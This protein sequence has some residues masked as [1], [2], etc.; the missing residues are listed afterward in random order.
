M[1]D[2]THGKTR[3]FTSSS[4]AGPYLRPQKKIKRRSTP[5][6]EKQE[7]K[8]KCNKN[9]DKFKINEENLS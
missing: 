4:S 8:E 5:S 1:M 6:E 9:E 3:S 7:D 2:K